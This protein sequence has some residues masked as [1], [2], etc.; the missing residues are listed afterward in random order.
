MIGEYVVAELLPGG[1]WMAR[2]GRHTSLEGAIADATGSYNVVLQ[3]VAVA[4]TK[5]EWETK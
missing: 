3:V 5:K 4:S 2:P 1:V